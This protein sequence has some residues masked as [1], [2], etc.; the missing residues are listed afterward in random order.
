MQRRHW[1]AAAATLAAIP[2][3]A[4]A[5]N[6]G[7]EG[8]DGVPLVLGAAWRGPREDD[9]Q[10]AGAIEVDWA[11]RRVAIRWSQ[12]LPTRAH[13]L[14]AEDDGSL[15]VVAVRPGSWLMRC[16]AQGRVAR[17][18]S[19]DDE[20]GGQRLNG[21]AVASADGRWIFTT[22]SDASGRG[23][24]AV[25]ERESLRA[26]ELWPTQG[27]EPHQLLLAA[28]GDLVV[29]NGGILRAP[30]DRKRDLER[31]DSS[32]VRLDTRSG[33]LRG[34]WS[35]P[36]RRLSLRHLAWGRPT[37]ESA[38]LLGVALQ[39]EHDDPVQRAAAPLLAVWDGN[40]LRAVG[41]SGRGAGYAGDIAAAGPGGFA[42]S[43]HKV[44]RAF[45]WWP[46]RGD[47]FSHFAELDEPY[48]LAAPERGADGGG[49]VMA[50]AAGIVRWHPT[51]SAAMLRWPA[52]MALDNHWVVMNG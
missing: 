39:A 11:R 5:D 33:A 21:H 28:N 37:D 52:P 18:T 9:A 16:D 31:M 42:L 47:A 35:L 40:E 20:A 26:L 29:A 50:C 14:L 4:R 27:I 2:G 46:Q 48:A 45:V 51:R 13:G 8:G 10:R 3:I 38:P 36:D 19:I 6:E 23:F 43:N 12:P 30:G 22:Q 41:A 17:R 44:R 1:L 34:Q 15:L 32:L 24:V 25:R 7:G 49:V